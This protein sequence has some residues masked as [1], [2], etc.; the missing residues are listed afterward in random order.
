MIK[1]CIKELKNDKNITIT[2]PDKGF[3]VVIS[4]S[5]DYVSKIENLLNDCTKFKHTGSINSIDFTA[6][7]ELFYQGKC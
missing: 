5:S 7:I 2:K 4:N 6:R 1:D 3:S